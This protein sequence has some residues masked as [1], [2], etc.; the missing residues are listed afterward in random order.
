MRNWK[1][2]C[3]SFIYQEVVKKKE[4]MI[5][6]GRI[7]KDLFEKIPERVKEKRSNYELTFAVSCWEKRTCDERHSTIVE[8]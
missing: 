6:P 3:P 1:A 2:S 4:R 8:N 7:S 5:R